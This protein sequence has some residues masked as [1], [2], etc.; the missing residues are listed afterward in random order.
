MT[1]VISESSNFDYVLNILKTDMK[2][3]FKS[4]NR[5]LVSYLVVQN[6]F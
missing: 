4:K 5:I 3:S 1:V 6:D 2:V